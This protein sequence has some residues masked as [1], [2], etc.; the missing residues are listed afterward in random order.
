MEFSRDLNLLLFQEHIEMTELKTLKDLPKYPFDEQYTELVKEDAIVLSEL[1]QEAIKWVKKC[2][3]INCST[4]QF[5]VGD[6]HITLTKEIGEF[7][8]MFFNITEEEN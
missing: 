3:D 2:N 8:K 1:R 6:R 7:I 5:N 4:C